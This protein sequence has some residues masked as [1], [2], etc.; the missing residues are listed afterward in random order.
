MELPKQ[1]SA[2]QFEAELDAL[3]ARSPKIPLVPLE[4][5][6][7]EAIYRGHD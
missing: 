5:L 2:E 6:M 3:A 1:M 4:A 7:R